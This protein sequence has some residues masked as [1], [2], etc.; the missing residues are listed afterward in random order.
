[1][2]GQDETIKPFMRTVRRLKYFPITLVVCYFW[3][4]VSRVHNMVIPDAPIFWLYLLQLLFKS[5]LGLVN[6][7][8]YT[9]N[10]A[11]QDAWAS[12][13][14]NSSGYLALQK[15]WNSDMELVGQHDDDDADV[16]VNGD[17]TG[18]LG[19]CGEKFETAS[20]DQRKGGA[21]GEM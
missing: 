6:A 12:L 2:H 5:L 16:G 3:A 15:F 9:S 7:V 21:A 14:L 8:L 11:V 13:L 1:L 4:T 18:Q 19:H 17:D 20:D 10:P